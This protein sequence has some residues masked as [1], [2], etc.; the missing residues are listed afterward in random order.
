MLLYYKFCCLYL[1]NWNIFLYLQHLQLLFPTW[2]SAN[3]T[4][5]LGPHLLPS[6]HPS[7]QSQR[8]LMTSNQ[9]LSFPAGNLLASPKLRLKSQSLTL[10]S[11]LAQVGPAC[12]PDLTSS[13]SPQGLCTFYSRYQEHCYCYSAHGWHLLIIP[14]SLS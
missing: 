1:P 8:D 14:R 3:V 5:L 13:S 9:S 7:T 11:H 12:F 10:S 2:T 6:P 4:Y